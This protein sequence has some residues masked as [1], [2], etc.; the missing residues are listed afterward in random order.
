M[1][2]YCITNVITGDCYVGQTRSSENK[3]MRNHIA[4]AKH[5]KRHNK[6]MTHLHN[7]ILKYGHTNFTI[8]SLEHVTDGAQLD[9][10]EMFWISKLNPRYNMTDG[11]G[12]MKGVKRTMSEETKRKISESRKGKIWIYHPDTLDEAQT[13]NIDDY[14]GWIKG[15]SPATS[16]GG[17]RGIYSLERSRNAN[18]KKGQRAHNKGIKHSDETISKLKLHAKE[19]FKDGNGNFKGKKHSPESIQKMRDAHRLRFN[20]KAPFPSR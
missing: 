8:E 16:H 19:R 6:K 2:I 5:N 15:R 14:P 13:K 9:F 18:F 20:E 1:L 12:G 10:R 4:L 3:R 7:A 11:G 17:H